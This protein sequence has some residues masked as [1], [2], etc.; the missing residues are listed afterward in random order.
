MRRKTLK[1]GLGKLWYQRG[2]M[3][4]KWGVSL[5]FFCFCLYLFVLI[6]ERDIFLVYFSLFVGVW[7]L[8][9]QLKCCCL[10]CFVILT[11]LIIFCRGI[12]SLIMIFFLYDAKGSSEAFLHCVAS[13]KGSSF[14]S[15]WPGNKRTSERLQR[16]I[17]L[18]K[19]NKKE[20]YE[21]L[22]QDG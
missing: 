20:R 11:E 16:R 6:L 13:L 5:I 18:L 19:K 4:A 3:Y 9:Q 17:F 12:C 15:S 1:C 21:I 10:F 14:C 8:G 2:L 22:C 7:V